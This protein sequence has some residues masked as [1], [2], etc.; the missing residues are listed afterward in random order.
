[1]ESLQQR[2]CPH[3]TMRDLVELDVEDML[4]YDPYENETQ[5][6]EVFPIL[7][8]EPEVTPEWGTNK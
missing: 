7:Y 6:D 4:Q 2:L 8:K 5:N 3:A 1:M